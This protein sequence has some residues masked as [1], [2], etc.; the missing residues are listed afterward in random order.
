MSGG[1]EAGAAPAPEAGPPA[2]P[3]AGIDLAAAAATPGAWLELSVAADHEAVE[4]VSEILSRAAPGGTSVEP[5]FELVEEG[6]AARVDFARPAIVRA[7][8][9]VRDVAAIRSAV[10]RTDRELG[11]LQAFGMRPIGELAGGHRPGGRLGQRL[12]GALP[13][14]P[15]RP[16]HRHPPHLAAPPAAAG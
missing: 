2:D 14:A 1:S 13:G 11:H 6:L 9:P 15:Y 10:A 12:E 8:L 7:H 4:A 16:A 3:L 5:A